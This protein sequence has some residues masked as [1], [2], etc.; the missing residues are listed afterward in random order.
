[1]SSYDGS[2]LN[3]SKEHADASRPANYLYVLDMGLDYVLDEMTKQKVQSGT[4]ETKL[5]YYDFRDS[6]NS[7]CPQGYV[8]Q[9]W[10]QR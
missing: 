3:T 4:V 7:S 2:L 9:N 10:M 6:Q 1:M 8:E 5:R